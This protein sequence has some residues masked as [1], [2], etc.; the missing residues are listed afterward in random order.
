MRTPAAI[1]SVQAGRPIGPNEQTVS[2]VARPPMIRGIPTR[3]P[4]YQQ[5]PLQVPRSAAD[6]A[7]AAGLDPSGP[8]MTALMKI[9]HEVVERIVWEVVPE[10]AETIIRENLTRLNNKH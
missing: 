1:A 10:L 9:S 2:G 7:R 5:R 3:R 6:L 4:P 8:E